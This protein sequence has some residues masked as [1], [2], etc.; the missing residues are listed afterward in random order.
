MRT[1]VKPH[2]LTATSL[3]LL[4][5]LLV[6]PSVVGAQPREGETLGRAIVPSDAEFAATDV[7][8]PGDESSEASHAFR[9]EKAFTGP[10]NGGV[11]RDARDGGFFEV[12]LK[13]DPQKAQVLQATYWGSDGGREFDISI[14]GTKL[15]TEKIENNRPG[16]FFN[17]NYTLP[18]A[19]TR[20]KNRITVRFESVNGRTAGGVYGLAVGVPLPPAVPRPNPVISL[21][22]DANGLTLNQQNGTLQLQV[23]S[24]RVVR[25]FYSG[26]STPAPTSSLAVIA[27]PSR[28]SWNVSQSKTQIVL[29]TAS[30]QVRV[31]RA[32]GAVAFTDAAGNA[33]LSEKMGGKQLRP[34]VVGGV[35]TLRS[36][37]EFVL[38]PD[39]AIFGLGQHQ[40]GDMN[41]RVKTVHLQQRN[42]DVAVPVLVSSK[43]YGVLWDTPA[44]TDVNVGARDA[45]TLSWSSEAGRAVDYYFM[46]GPEIDGVI[47]G[48]RDLTGKA[49]MFARYSWGL[50]QSRERYTSQQE[51][52]DV[53]GKY[54]A[55]NIPLDG[56]IQDWQYWNPNPWGSH[57]FDPARYPDPKGMMEQLHR[58]NA[59]LL[60]SVW[61]KF[62]VDSP[63]AEEFRKSNAVYPEVIP[64]VY[65]QGKGQWYDPFN[66]IG[67]QIYWRQMKDQLFAAGVDGWW[68]DGSEA[69][70]SGNWGEFRNYKTGG[71]PG[72][73]VFNAYPLM[74]TTAV[75][76]GQ[77]AATSSKRVYI[78]T[79]SAYAGQQ[80]NGATT[81]S[82]DIGANWDVLTNQIPAGI[83]FTLSGIPYWN[84]DTGG[85]FGNNPDDPKWREL[86]TRWFQ[87]STFCPM[88]RVHGTDKPKELWRFTGDTRATLENYDQLRYHLLPYIYSTSWRVTSEGYTMMRGLVMD[89]RRDPQVYGIPDQY[90]FGPA[91]MACPVTR[92][93]ATSRRVYLP[94]GTTWTDFWTGQTYRGGQNIE[95]A[96][97]IS[98][99]PLFVKAGSILPYGP[100]VQS[101]AEKSDPLELRIYG[102]ADGT[103]T[104][105]EDEGDNYNYEK[106]AYATIPFT[107]NE[108]S[109]TLLIGARKG[110][111]PGM[112]TNRT[113]R[114]VW[115]KIGQGTGT[116]STTQADAE[117]KYDG[118]ATRVR[119]NN[120]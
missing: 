84:T 94:K 102:G 33:L 10:A 86:F 29:K 98:T 30:L 50:W 21:R 13:Y 62:D 6:P 7:F 91:L 72:A 95:A 55:A 107:W 112:M 81:W 31:N 79:R 70:L 115:V 114:I 32:T 111:F 26:N 120:K 99:M 119:F 8:L 28:T 110:K 41:Y 83:N 39:E 5:G 82:G 96:A 15:L 54:R 52:L 105:Y 74:H 43:G 47:A 63:N 104:L 97:P 11:F 118:K 117:V 16:E 60:I 69:E 78:L 44:I 9:G 75:Y 56:I 12:T 85:F 59:H 93:G 53:V 67:R 116:A 57:K 76:Q 80:R 88:L 64:Y 61:P 22:R 71:G 100:S 1:K 77:R 14:D 49:P 42:T 35:N 23:F 17:V 73:E 4:A 34:A 24:P 25:V 18:L 37:Q 66:P 51:L 27:R 109:Q 103:F 19:L 89:F 108:K 65:P 40:N 46:Y 36:R 20:G 58:E 106:G 45:G 38:A 92:E 3:L 90:M 113:F 101:S 68:L 48:Y 87:F 2:L